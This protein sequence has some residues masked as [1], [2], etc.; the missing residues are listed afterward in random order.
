MTGFFISLE[1]IEGSGKSSCAEYLAQKLIKNDVQV[2]I[3]REPG[4]TKTGEQ[5]RDILLNPNNEQIAPNTELL[6][7]FAA[8]SQHITQIIIPALTANHVVICD[9]FMD[10][11]YAYQGAGRNISHEII[12]N[13]QNMFIPKMPDLTLLCDVE[14]EEGLKRAKNRSKPDRFERENIN[15]FKLIRNAYLEQAKLDTRRIKIID[16]NQT[17]TDVYQ[18]LESIIRQIIEQVQ[19]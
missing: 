16:N 8:R 6:L 11:T 12:A 9:R 19:K 7:M 13:L 15:F 10:S 5:I 3:T 1:G 17:I 18:Q 2:I 14:V 4:G